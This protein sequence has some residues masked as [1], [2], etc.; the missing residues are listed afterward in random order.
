MLPTDAPHP[1]EH[2]YKCALVTFDLPDILAKALT[3]LNQ[4]CRGYSLY[5]SARNLPAATGTLQWA[6]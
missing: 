5:D 6:G 4:T 3:A 1:I 2:H